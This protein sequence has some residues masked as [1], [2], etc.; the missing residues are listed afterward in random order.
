MKKNIIIM[1]T[2]L[3]ALMM[4]VSCGVVHALGIAPSLKIIDYDTLEHTIDITVVNTEASDLTLKIAAG[5]DLSPYITIDNDVIHLSST[6]S[7]KTFQ[8]KITLPKDMDPGTKTGIITA[9]EINSG[10]ENGT[11]VNAALSV[12]HKLLVTVPSTGLHA[13]A[14]L[15]NSESETGSPMT[16][17]LSINNI[18]T[19]TI[20]DTYG[21]V[22]ISSDSFTYENTTGHINNIAPGDSGKIDYTWTPEVNPGDYTIT[23]TV[24]YDNK[25]ISLSKSVS[26]GSYNI[27][28][29]NASVKDFYIGTVAKLDINVS[30]NWNNPIATNTEVQILDGNGTIIKQA[31][32][33]GAAIDSAGGI[34]STYI[35]TTGVNAGDYT[36]KITMKYGSKSLEKTYPMKISTNKIEIG[37]ISAEGEQTSHSYSYLYIVGAVILIIIIIIAIIFSTR[38]RSRKI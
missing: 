3:C 20:K 8:Y 16:I 25:S 12:A 1:Y 36:L 27:D 19:E 24:Y 33:D 21:T 4:L 5:G 35:D 34:V 32:V 9:T 10:S 17:S 11:N 15:S 28:I 30:N 14:F 31:S 6:D 7:E 38:K 29:T 18:G 37:A 22:K 23:A 13:T 2:V 26:I